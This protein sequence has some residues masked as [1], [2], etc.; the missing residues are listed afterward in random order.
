MP[1]QRQRLPLAGSMSPRPV[2][3]A[4]VAATSAL[5]APASV[6][7]EPP[8]V[9]AI[10]WDAYF[11]APGMPK[12]EDPNYGI[13]ARAT[14]YDLSPQKWHYRVPFY[15]QELNDTAITANGDTQAAMGAELDYA[16]K[17]GIQ[18]WSFCNYPIGCVDM[19]PPAS[20]CQKIQCCADNVGLSYA[21]NQYLA[22]PDNHKVNFTLLLQP[23]YWFP[24]ALKGG[25]ETL[26]QEVARY[27]SYFKMA[28]Y[29]K[30][31][32]GRPLVFLFGGAANQSDL[33]V[34]C[35]ATQR[36]L[37]VA[38]YIASM[39]DQSLPEIDAASWYVTTGGSPEG[40]PYQTA[41]AGPESARWNKLASAGKKVIPTVS[42]GWDSRP[43][44]TYPCTYDSTEN[45]SCPWG[46]AGSPRYTVDPT[47]EEL[48]AHTLE[49]LEWVQNNSHAGGAC[50]DMR[51]CVL[52]G[53]RYLC[54]THG[55]ECASHCRGGGGKHDDA[56]G[57]ERA[58]RGPLDRARPRP[59]RR[60]R[61][62]SGHQEGRR[63]STGAP[64]RLLG[65]ALQ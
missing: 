32:G 61:K 34:L 18:F 64:R 2:L 42:A 35:K 5:V 30:V 57:L 12:F 28:N 23:G 62:A 31:L 7:A 8:I 16:Q 49:G 36:A 39:S 27:I 22:H 4:V 11:E 14:T 29:Q 25:N 47:M 58:R 10:R 51:A 54:S 40:A 56:V 6:V 41:I 48:T 15:G 20:E 13:V 59:V 21:W 37:G 26:D 53:Y 44:T 9:G 1:E 55:R 52:A 63:Q 65:T 60:R 38:P 19:H 43:R 3:A 24:T 46:G 45:C 17:H 33:Q 50:P